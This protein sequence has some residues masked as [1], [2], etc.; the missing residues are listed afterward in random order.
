MSQLLTGL[1]IIS[2]PIIT[3]I[4]GKLINYFFKKT[5]IINSIC[6]PF[7]EPLLLENLSSKSCYI[8]NLDN[9]IANSLDSDEKEQSALGALI[10]PRVV[11]EKSISIVEGLKDIILNST[12][13]INAFL[14]FSI[15][16][17]LLKYSGVG[18]NNILYCIP[19]DAYYRILK[20]SIEKFDDDLYL[21][22]KNDLVL[23]KSS[24]IHIYNSLNELNALICQNFASITIKI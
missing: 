22:I 20:S 5:A 6:M 1:T 14:F 7:I 13:E 19:S 2:K 23:R 17:R 8:V 12:N 18:A 11:F 15:D 3:F 9:E 16:Y 24:K 4:F 10:S 21:K